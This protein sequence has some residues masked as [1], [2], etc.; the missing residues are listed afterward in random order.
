MPGKGY[1]YPSESS[2][3]WHDKF[4]IRRVAGTCMR[5]SYLRLTGAPVTNPPDAYNEWIFA[6]GK[7]VEEI[8]VEQ[9]KQMGIWVENNLKFLDAERSISGEIDVILTEPNGSLFGVE[10]KSFYGYQATR[11]L[12]GNTKV[13]AAPK[14]SQLIQAMIY[15]D[16]FKDILSYFK[17][18]YYARDSAARNEFDITLVPI[19]GKRY[20][21]INGEVD[22]RFSLE[23]VYE[24][25]AILKQYLQAKE[26]PP[27]DF[28]LRWSE[29]KINQRK[30]LG[31]VS[32]SAYEEW[33]KKKTSIGDWQCRFCPYKVNCWGKK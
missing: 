24:R 28:E 21:A 13:K 18:V 7:A 3:V 1:F 23:D 27:A 22:S 10:V 20:P 11:D 9:W 12:I 26:L 33:Q 5:K 25:F 16:Q 14:T 15:V 32:K 31:E 2:A 17:M 6:L 19:D 4:G 29:E 30:E 8:L